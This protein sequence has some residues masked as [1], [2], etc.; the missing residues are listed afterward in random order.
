MTLKGQSCFFFQQILLI[1]K[2]EESNR[3]PRYLPHHCP[4]QRATR[5][6]GLA[7]IKRIKRKS[8]SSQLMARLGLSSGYISCMNGRS[9]LTSR[10]RICGTITKL[11]ATT[12]ELGTA[13]KKGAEGEE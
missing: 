2:R 5:V 11:M 4:T 6:E 13:G 12:K 7:K 10:N 1:R 3:L 8:A 9:L